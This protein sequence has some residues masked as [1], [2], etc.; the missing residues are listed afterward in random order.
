MRPSTDNQLPLARIYDRLARLDGG[1]QL[2]HDERRVVEL[3]IA[4]EANA[5]IAERL[6]RSPRTVASE[7][8][9]AFEKLDVRSRRELV[10]KLSGPAARPSSRARSRKGG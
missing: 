3:T 6:G 8:R 10:A 9:A 7:L 5:Q 1:M 2:T 4:G